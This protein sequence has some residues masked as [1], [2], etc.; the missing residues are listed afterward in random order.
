MKPFKFLSKTN[1]IQPPGNMYLMFNMDD[2]LI[3]V[4]R[5]LQYHNWEILNSETYMSQVN[6]PINNCFIRITSWRRHVNPPIRVQ[7]RY[8]VFE[9]NTFSR[10]F[11][12]IMNEE[13]FLRRIDITGI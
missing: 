3:N 13:E 4:I 5:W 1:P 7:I 2:A 12:F 6:V 10:N 11:T 8:S 9:A